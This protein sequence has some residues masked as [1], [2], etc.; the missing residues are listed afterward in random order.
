M[1]PIES[2][3]LG[4]QHLTSG[5]LSYQVDFEVVRYGAGPKPVQYYDQMVISM[6]CPECTDSQ[7]IKRLL[8]ELA[9]RL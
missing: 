8:L 3:A 7:M 2:F 1:G 5:P 6:D 9:N 4:I